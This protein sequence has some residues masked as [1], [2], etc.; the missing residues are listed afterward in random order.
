MKV[1]RHKV[2]ALNPALRKTGTQQG[3]GA[4]G[5]TGYRASIP[6]EAKGEERS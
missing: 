2:E 3:W 6:Y 4:S 5:A 1:I